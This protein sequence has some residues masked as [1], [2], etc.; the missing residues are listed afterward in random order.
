MKFDQCKFYETLNIYVYL[1]IP[2]Y[3]LSLGNV[4]F[5]NNNHEKI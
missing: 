2:L 5:N 1:S 3:Y 4:C